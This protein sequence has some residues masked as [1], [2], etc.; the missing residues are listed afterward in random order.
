MTD[1]HSDR[2]RAETS[3]FPLGRV[4]AA[5]FALALIERSEMLAALS[6]HEHGDWGLVDEPDKQANERAFLEGTRLLSV[7]ESQSGIRFWIITEADRSL[8][9]VLLPEDYLYRKL[10]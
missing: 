3:K 8:T 7:Y 4:V 1:N 6:R 10:D 2:V 5:P 9:C